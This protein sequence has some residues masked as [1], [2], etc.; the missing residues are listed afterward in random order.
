[1]GV[2]DILQS[3]RLFKQMEHF[4]KSIVHNKDTFSVIPPLKYARRFMA[5]MERIFVP[6]QH[7][8]RFN[9]MAGSAATTTATTSTPRWNQQQQPRGAKATQPVEET[10]RGTGSQRP[11][12]KRLPP[13]SLRPPPPPPVVGKWSS[14]STSNQIP[15][16]KPAGL[17]GLLTSSKR[18]PARPDEGDQ[19][20]LDEGRSDR[21]R[22]TGRATLEPVKENE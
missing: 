5:A 7:L 4:F 2:I 22:G 20:R 16:R 14:A 18:K 13:P 15:P 10:K 1:M 11:E 6:T 19:G 17:R 12:E 21:I 3:Y 9:K 8:A